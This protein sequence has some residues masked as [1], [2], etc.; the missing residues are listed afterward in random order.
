MKPGRILIL[1]VII[2]AGFII[3]YNKFR[4]TGPANPNAGSKAPQAV[5]V[6]AVVASGSTIENEIN[7][8]GSILANEEAEVR[9]EIGG[10]VAAIYFKE[11]TAVTKGE[12][13]VKIVDDLRASLEKLILQKELATKNEAR[14][15]DLLSIKG[16]S[17]QDYETTLNQLNTIKADIDFVKASIAKT[18]IRAPFDGIIG[19]KNISPGSFLAPNTLIA[20]IQDIDP[21]KVEFS[22]PEKYREMISLSTEIR[23]T[24]QASQKEFTGQVYAFEPKIDL[25]TRSFIV[26]ALSPNHD[27]KIFPGSFVNVSVPFKKLENSIVIPTQCV[28][29]DMKGKTVFVS[30]NGL[31]A[32]VRVQTGI[33][34]DSTI[35]ITDGIVPGDTILTTGIMQVRPDMPLKIT[36]VN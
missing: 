21:V 33:R 13:L 12:L 23:F 35:Q 24:T 30:R 14:Q 36:V 27:K 17:E 19:L 3:Y 6:N 4:Q 10:R 32:K 28:I 34:N 31:A 9:N 22:I 8:T 11:G 7:A 29:P 2:L 15:K 25:E 26:R 16:I 20:R 5:L 18:E 1:L